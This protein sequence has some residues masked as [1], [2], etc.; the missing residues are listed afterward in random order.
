MTRMNE[1]YS[2]RNNA[3][4]AVKRFGPLSKLGEAFGYSRESIEWV[5]GF[6]ERQRRRADISAEETEI[7]LQLIGSYL[8]ECLIYTYGGFWRIQNGEWGVFFNDSNAA[9]PF[10][11]V[12]KQF[13]N[14][15][16]GGDSILSFFE[17]TRVM[18]MKES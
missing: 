6:I 3:E 5:E 14:G 16:D 17:M 8:G 4:L 2:F 12:R 1:I 7:L 11:K 15:I 10:S 18:I 9:F 13:E